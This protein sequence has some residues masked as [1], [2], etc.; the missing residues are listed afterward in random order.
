M[1]TFGK[2]HTRTR[3]GKLEIHLRSIPVERDPDPLGQ[4]ASFVVPRKGTSIHRFNP[5]L[6]LKQ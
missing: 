1:V 2:F 5:T 4:L 6:D 3:E